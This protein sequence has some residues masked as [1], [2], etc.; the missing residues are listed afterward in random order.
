MKH[1]DQATCGQLGVALNQHSKALSAK[2]VLLDHAYD[3]QTQHGKTQG[4]YLTGH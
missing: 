1:G 2:A 3:E 4:T